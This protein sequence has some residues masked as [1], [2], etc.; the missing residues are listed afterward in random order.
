MD[1]EKKIIIY[2]FSGTGNT[3]IVCGLLM[4]ALI[5]RNME[6]SMI[7]MEDVSFGA[8]LDLLTPS[9]MIGIASPIHG[10]GVP[11][12]VSQKT[13]QIAAM[14]NRDQQVFLLLTGADMVK[15]NHAAAS[16]ISNIFLK[17]DIKIFYERLI[18]MASNFMVG[19]NER[20]NRQLYEVS[21]EKTAH[22]A[23]ELLLGR[24]RELRPSA[25]YRVI[26]TATHKCESGPGASFFGNSIRSD[27]KCTGCMTCVKNCP[28][29]NLKITN[30]KIR[31]GKD[32]LMCMRCFYI[33]PEKALTSKSFKFPI[34]KNGYDP[35]NFTDPSYSAE[36]FLTEKT[37]GFYRHF[38]KYIKNKEL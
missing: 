31:G 38:L 36:P 17:K 21:K 14:A 6:V 23:D 35:K 16:A 7:S 15:I 5:K 4:Q 29:Q 10:F 30:G 34:L 37:K 2:Y 19:Y 9:D 28:V 18:V 12:I 3:E 11:K 13:K 26:A 33:C 1:T 25:F 8:S 32:C 27:D 24:K 22:M 20:F